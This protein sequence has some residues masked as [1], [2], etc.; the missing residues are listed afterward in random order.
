[1]P[2]LPGLDGLRALAVIGVLLYHAD[3]NVSGGFLGVE[4]FF[5]LSG[6]LITS[7]LLAEWRQRSGIDLTAFWLR[8]ARRLLP[9]LFL[10][11]LGT[12]VLAGL[13]LRGETAGLRAD[14]LA[15]LSYVMN[16]HLVFSGQ[17]YFDPLAR[18]SLLQNLW[19]LAVEEQ[20]YLLWPLLFTVGMR[21]L[22]RSGLLLATLGAAAASAL[23]MA[24][25]YQPGAD[26]SR[27]YFGTDTRASG[28][29]LGA[30]LA[31]GW[32]PRRASGST[33]RG[34]GAL[35]DLLGIVVLGGLI[36]AFIAWY[37]YQPL[38]YRGGFA[39]VA[40]GTAVVIVAATH[41][42]A[43]LLPALLEWR[44]L[45]WIGQRSYGIY[46]WYWPIFMF[47]R[48][49]VDVPLGGWP[50][51]A[52]RL[53]IVIALAALSFRYV[54][55]PARRGAVGRLW[56]ALW[57]AY[58]P[59][60]KRDDSEGRGAASWPG[61]ANARWRWASLLVVSILLLGSGG[62]C[63]A[64]SSIRPPAAPETA[65]A[66]T[67]IA[68][69]STAAATPTMEAPATPTAAPTAT[70]TTAA[71]TATV[72]TATATATSTTTSTPAATSTQ[73]APQA[74]DP[75]LAAEL[76]RILDETVAG[77]NIPGAV[78]SVYIPGQQLWTGASGVR[79]RTTGQPMEPTTLFRIASISKVFTAV[80]MLQLVE[81]GKIDLNAPI[82]TWLPGLVPNGDAITVRNLL[83]Q[84][85]GLY[86]YLE[87][88]N[89]VNRAF[90][91]PN[92]VWT[93]RELVEYA[94]QFPPTFAP[95]AKGAWDYSS[96]NYVLLGMIV[97]Q[98]TGMP[99][100]RVMRQRIFAPLE[101]QQTFFLPDEAIQG[102]LA[103]GYSTTTD[104]TNAPMSFVFA[105]ANIVSTVE[106][107]Q[108][109]IRALRDGQLL[110]PTTLAMMFDFVNGKGQYDMPDLEYGFGLMRNRLPVGPGP[111]GRPRPAAA[112]TVIGHIGG[113][114]GFR[115]AV[116]SAPESGITIA[117]AVNQTVTDP[118]ILATQVFDAI[119]KWQGR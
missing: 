23:L 92:R 118:N 80:V 109:F 110:K 85:S 29:L 114:G 78:L 100:A 101:L 67:A 111:D 43:R 36:A 20:F 26:P 68:A 87:D 40:I 112:S 2:Y 46:L 12:L 13:L 106:N 66:T 19:S 50:L 55:L 4:S 99:L 117:L 107:V 31:L 96:T 89:F 21:Y 86:D 62:S 27:L 69:G 52:L 105:T 56:R 79:D 95:G 33:R 18:P 83:S 49:Y 32:T 61:S 116:W 108:R 84:T 119:L 42:G 25:L 53:P 103:R 90:R 14:M 104:R 11:L 58:R 24:S 82:A 74:F 28:L 9:A 81:E 72:A 8:R 102:V 88:R 44:P 47:T 65:S 48:P 115:S 71:P 37:D 76:Q 98:A 60:A 39:M 75:A 70:V 41:P 38:L 59:A 51:L 16:W 30:A 54:E 17:S 45:R 10:M 77:G 57:A 35:L 91:E 73:V 7:L 15:A 64:P 1:M 97:E 5:V 63:A 34:A 3:L 93:P 113:Y 94:V 22:R 6:F